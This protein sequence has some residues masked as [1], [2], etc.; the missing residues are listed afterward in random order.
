MKTQYRWIYL[1]GLILCLASCSTSNEITLEQA[2]K[3]Y[4]ASNY[5]VLHTPN[6]N[7]HL[8]DFKLSNDSLTGYLHPTRDRFGIFLAFYSNKRFKGKVNKQNHPYYA[9]H[10]DEI[11]K[12][13]TLEEF[14]GDN[15]FAAYL[16]IDFLLCTIFMIL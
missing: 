11:Y 6:R 5:A 14:S 15:A 9:V 8:H 3:K 13:K 12:T 1:F 10:V 4:V 2:R 16:I 7:F